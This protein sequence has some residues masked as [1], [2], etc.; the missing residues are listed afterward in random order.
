MKPLT[1]EHMLILADE[2]CADS[3]TPAPTVRSFAALCAAAAIPGAR[4]HGVA[5]FDSAG[6]AADALAS[7]IRRLAP[8]TGSDDGATNTAFAS[9]VREVY[10]RWAEE[11]TAR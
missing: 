8:L 1:S 9:F 11:T 7:G 6:A 5:V 10:L 2:F 3:P 4:I